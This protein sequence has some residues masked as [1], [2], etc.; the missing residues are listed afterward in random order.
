MTLRIEHGTVIAHRDG[1]PVVLEDHTVEV[2]GAVITGVH[3]SSD[4]RPGSSASPPTNEEVIDASRHLVIPG[5]VN[6]HHHLYQSLTRGMKGV[7]DAGLFRWL[8][9][10]YPVWRR[11]DFEAVKLASQI[12]IA[13]LLLSGCTTTND[14]FYLFPHGGDVTI[15]AVLE[16][17]ESLGI[18]IHACRGSMSVGQSKGGLPPDV[19]VQG[20]AEILRDC[21]RVVERFHDPAKYS[22]RRIDLAPCSPFSV[23]AEL[24]RDTAALARERGVLLHTHAAETGDE[25]RYCRERFGMGPIEWLREAGWLG[26]DV[27]LAHCIHLDDADIARLAETKTG[28]AHCPCSNMRLGSGVSPIRRMLDAGVK[29]GLG[30]DGS[31]SNDGGHLLAEARQA[32]LLQRVLGGAEAL[33]VAEAFRLGT[34]GSAAVLNR[35]ELGNIEIGSAADIAMFRADDVAL[36]GAVAHDPLGALMLCH[37]GRADCV[38]VNGRT[39]VQD[40]NIV[41][42]DPSVLA[43]RLN[44]LVRSGF[45]K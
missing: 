6:S 9:A 14:H 36:A 41:G 11:I 21:Q 30:V 18:R 39:I 4:A 24:L 44:R 38:I 34:V 15:E 45:L 2:E 17:A 10:L 42:H 8:E 25:E 16:A 27:Y 13:E 3:P 23:S 29:V 31:S 40:G 28:V 19:C 22:M 20:E 32:L 5:L 43:E 35:P 26:E 37:V 1:A 7:Q 33:R 12:S